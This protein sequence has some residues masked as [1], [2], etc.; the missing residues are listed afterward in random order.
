MTG[1][2]FSFLFRDPEHRMFLGRGK[3]FR[4]LLVFSS[5]ELW[6]AIWE[7]TTTFFENHIDIENSNI[8]F[9][10]STAVFFF[11]KKHC[12][13]YHPPGPRCHHGQRT[14]VGKKE[15]SYFLPPY[16]G[17]LHHYCHHFTLGIGLRRP[18]Y[19]LSINSKDCIELDRKI[20]VPA[21]LQYPILI[22]IPWGCFSWI[23]SKQFSEKKTLGGVHHFFLRVW[24][25]QLPF[26]RYVWYIYIY[27][28]FMYTYVYVN[29]YIYTYLQFTKGYTVYTNTYIYIQK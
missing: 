28:S 16:R 23:L 27:I 10:K 14:Q 13:P 17:S 6:L 8:I 22:Q 21:N 12:D 5:S 3:D 19:I 24:W 11:P 1:C 2:F 20:Y 26:S 4:C 9:P 25:V 15:S 7:D 18:W 29:I